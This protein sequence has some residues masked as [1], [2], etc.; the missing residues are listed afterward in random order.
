M[1]IYIEKVNYYEKQYNNYKSDKYLYKLNKYLYKLNGGGGNTTTNKNNKTIYNYTKHNIIKYFDKDTN[2][3]YL[4]I[5][6]KSRWN[7]YDFRDY[8]KYN[9]IVNNIKFKNLELLKETKCILD[10]K[11]KIIILSANIGKLFNYPNEQNITII[12]NNIINNIKIIYYIDKIEFTK[13]QELERDIKNNKNQIK[14][15]IDDKISDLNVYIIKFNEYIYDLKELNN[16][17]DGKYM[18]LIDR[19]QK[20]LI[21]LK[22]DLNKNNNIDKIIND[23]NKN[24]DIDKIINEYNEKTKKNSVKIDKKIS[25]LEEIYKTYISPTLSEQI[26]KMKYFKIIDDIINNNNKFINDKK[27]ID[28]Y[29]KTKEDEL[30]QIKNK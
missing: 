3:L 14:F 18:T 5:N 24:N 17:R 21:K 16:T 15:L 19:I 8:L 29:I 9:N 26:T 11:D 22:N 6:Q 27:N 25:E 13:E 7:I 2:I 23:L 28:D 12:N 4:H 30:K 10:D 1:N 20:D